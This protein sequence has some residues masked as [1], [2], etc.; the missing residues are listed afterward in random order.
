MKLNRSHH[1]EANHSGRHS[2]VRHARKTVSRS[3]VDDLFARMDRAMSD[4]GGDTSRMN[5]N[6]DA[7]PRRRLL[8]PLAIR[9]A[10]P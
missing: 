1:V 7:P 8:R 2:G 9:I 10:L 4:R 3:T 5:A 6:N